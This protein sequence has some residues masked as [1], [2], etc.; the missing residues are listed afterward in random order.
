MLNFIKTIKINLGVK[1]VSLFV[2]AVIWFGIFG[3]KNVEVT[4][5]INVRVDSPS[6][7]VPASEVPERVVVKLIGPKAFLRSVLDRPEEPIPIPLLKKDAGVHTYRF[8]NDLQGLPLGVRVA[9]IQ[10]QTV[11]VRLD[12]VRQRT[13]PLQL[14][15]EGEPRQ[16]FRVARAYL[17]PERVRIRGPRSHLSKLE[18]LTIRPVS[19]ADLRESVRHPVTFD[20]LPPGVEVEGPSPDVIIEV[21][22]T[23]VVSGSFRVKG[24]PIKVKGGRALIEPASVTIAYSTKASNPVAPESLKRTSFTAGVDVTKLKKG[25]HRVRINAVGPPG[26]TIHQVAPA[27]VQVTIQ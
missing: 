13:V 4:K 11:T 14:E 7:L 5:E 1:V 9:S 22:P 17:A 25:R 2:A 27:E 10:P 6:Y 8:P 19:V 23:T 26:V 3:S 16:G 15:L 20:V 12:L 21:V 24:V 18:F